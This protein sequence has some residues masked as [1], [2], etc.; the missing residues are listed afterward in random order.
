MHIPLLETEDIRNK[1]LNL[2]ERFVF[3]PIDKA[4]NNFGIICKHLYINIIKKELGYTK[5]EIKGNDVHTPL[6][7]DK[8]IIINKHKILM[9]DLNLNYRKTVSRSF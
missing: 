9:K 6:K 4:S 3:V 8:N 7:D 2:Q 1:L 5:T